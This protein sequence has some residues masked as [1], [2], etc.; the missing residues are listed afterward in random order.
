MAQTEGKTVFE[1]RQAPLL[2]RLAFVWRLVWHASIALAIVTVALGIGVIG[3]HCIEGMAW[4]DAI[5]NAAM[6]L[7]GMGPVGDLHTDAGKLFASAYALFAGLVFVVIVGVLFAPVF[8]R[9]LHRFHLD[10]IDEDNSNG[11]HQS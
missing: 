8:H 4:I 6:I 9:F 11:E 7:G 1:H 5:V 2:S 10:I 3:Y